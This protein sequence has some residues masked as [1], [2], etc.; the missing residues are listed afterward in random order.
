MVHTDER[1]IRSLEGIAE[2]FLT[3]DRPIVMRIDDS[4]VRV[5]AGAPL[6][7]RRARGYVPDPIPAPCDVTGIVGCGGVLKSTIAVGRGSACTVSQYVGS[8]ENAETLE[9]AATMRF[10]LL[11]LLGT[12]A[13]L[14]VLDRYPGTPLECIPERGV[15]TVRIQHHHA[16][17]AACLAENGFTGRALCVVYDGTGFGDDGTLWGGE[18]FLAD[19]YRFE[20]VGHLSPMLLPGGEAAIMHP[21]RAALGALFPLLGD[22][23][24]SLF[25]VIPAAEKLPVL[26][27]LSRRLHCI[28][29]SGMGRLFD[30]MS[31]LL[32]LALHR[33]YE[34]RPAVLLEAAAMASP[35]DRE[36]PGYTVPLTRDGSGMPVIDGARILME[37]LT[38]YRSGAAA[39]RVA[40]RFHASIAEATAAVAAEC[41][42]EFR[43][44]AVCLSGGCFQN[45]LLT[46]RTVHLL[47]KGGLT[48]LRH[49]LLPPSD[50]AVSFGQVVIAGMAGAQEVAARLPR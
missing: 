3:H 20:R 10:H 5:A 32:M 27:L 2:L 28:P 22:A 14:Y 6:L 30:A 34:G 31:A 42:A 36:L 33:G 17:A 29:S 37:A 25:P 40:A 48:P 39:G 9:Q 23:A 26:E 15:P 45:V 7:L 18:F 38:E 13:R 12:T 44:E 16:H 1:A 50:E 47:H 41:A 4:V 11:S 8:A 24:A 19:R 21:W 49:R 43:V 46:E 35:G